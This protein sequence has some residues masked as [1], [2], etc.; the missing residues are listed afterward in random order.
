MTQA[1]GFLKFSDFRETTIGLHWF[2]SD[3]VRQTFVLELIVD[4]FH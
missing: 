2:G 1:K 4:L 3:L